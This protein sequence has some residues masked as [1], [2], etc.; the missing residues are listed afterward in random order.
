VTTLSCDLRGLP[1]ATISEVELTAETVATFSIVDYTTFLLSSAGDARIILLVN[2]I[3]S[4]K[5][6]H[7]F[8]VDECGFVERK[9]TLTTATFSKLKVLAGD[10]RYLWMVTATS[11]SVRVA[12][13]AALYGVGTLLSG[14]RELTPIGVYVLDLVMNQVSAVIQSA[15]RRIGAERIQRRHIKFSQ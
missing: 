10:S 2:V 7:G 12:V 1:I 14:T 9:S 5:E 8:F 15:L 11:A 3:D 6:A 4:N 13:S